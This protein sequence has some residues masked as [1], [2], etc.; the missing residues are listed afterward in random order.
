[1]PSSRRYSLKTAALW[2]LPEDRIA[3]ER[4]KT[5]MGSTFLIA[6]ADQSVRQ[7]LSQALLGWGYK[8]IEAATAAEVISGLE[9]ELP[10]AMLLDM[11]L[12]GGSAREVLRQAK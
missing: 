12:S 4:G 9:Q 2:R 6:D 3:I 5:N 7:I 10:V 11:K 1:M 8:P